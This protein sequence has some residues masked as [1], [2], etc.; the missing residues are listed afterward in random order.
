[1]RCLISLDIFSLTPLDNHVN[2]KIDTGAS[3]NPLCGV[4]LL[5]IACNLIGNAMGLWR[6]KPDI[7]IAYVGKSELPQD[8]VSALEQAFTTIADDYN[9]DGEILVKIHQYIDG[10][11]SSD[12]ETAY[13]EYASEISLI[14]DISD[15]ESY[16]FLLDEPDNF[17][18][19]FQLLAAPD[20][21]CPDTRDYATT[22][23]VIAWP[24][25]T[26][27]SKMELGSYTTIILG[28][29]QTGSSQELLSTLYLGRR[30]LTVDNT[31]SRLTLLSNMDALSADGLYYAAWTM[32][33][34]EPYENSDGDTVDLYDAQLYFLLGEFKDAETAQ[35][36]LNTWLSAGR[37]N[38]EILSEENVTCNGQDYLLITYQFIHEDNPYVR[39]ISAFGV[40][41]N[42]AACIELTCREGF[43]ED[44]KTILI[45]F[46]NGCT[47]DAG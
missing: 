43:D 4:I 39:G 41:G 45:D 44:L 9:H 46:L 8:T 13:Y 28:E 25:C 31:D 38:Y 15:C 36:N 34:S 1:M 32:G 23:K 29:T 40:F 22:D 24:D 14:G 2:H 17:Q 16:F 20:G 42:H 47:Y 19:E 18:R 30:C 33:G 21:S 35:N 12:I 26:T 27:L 5:G 3:E 37:T 11:Q 10:I 6:K 7:Q